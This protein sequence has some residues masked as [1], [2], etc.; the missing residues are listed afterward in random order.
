MSSTVSQVAC[1]LVHSED[2]VDLQ[3]ASE[4]ILLG[5]FQLSFS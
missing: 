5:G 3:H 2:V 4:I 1:G